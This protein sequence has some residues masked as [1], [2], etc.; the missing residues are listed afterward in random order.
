MFTLP[1]S[2]EDSVRMVMKSSKHTG[3]E[4]I[5]A[6]CLYLRSK[7]Y[8]IMESADILDSTPR[9]VINI[10]ENYREGGL[11]KAIKDDPRPGRPKVIDDRMKS[12]V[13]ALVC[14]EPPEGFDRWTL[15]LLQDQVVE[16]GIISSVS[17]ESLRLILKEHDLKPWQH[18]MWCV[19]EID[20]EYVERMEDVLDLYSEPYKKHEPMVCI[21]EK[22][23]TLQSDIKAAILAKPGSV[24]KVDYEYERHGSINVFAMVEPKAGKYINKV[25]ELKTGDDFAEFI[26]DINDYY[27]D[28]D[29]IKLV[30]D[31][32]C[33]HNKNSLVKR[34]GEDKANEIW[35]RFEIHYTP[36]HGSWLNQAEIGIGMYQR[37]CLGDCRIPDIKTLEKKTLAWNRAINQKGVVINWKFNKKHARQKFGYG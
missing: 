12:E 33:T 26:A 22:P 1:Q 32:Y 8:T 27:R 10:T 15:E 14:S 2:D 25:T 23:V 19:G 17:K 28:A 20:E 36:V 4:R 16:N 35:D 5:R 11:S 13:V 21:D 37:Q 6:H 3:P 9:T 7:Q 34:F 30:M 31:N 29:Q 24:A 18:K